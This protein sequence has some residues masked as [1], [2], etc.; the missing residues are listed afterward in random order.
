MAARTPGN[1]ADRPAH[2]V[3]SYLLWIVVACALCGCSRPQ[4]QPR[5]QLQPCELEGVPLEAMCGKLTVFEDREA[6]AGRTIALNIAVV[7]ALNPDPLSDPLF[8]L[9]GGPGQSATKSG[10]MVAALLRGVRNHREIVLVDQRGTG[11]SNPL[12]CDSPGGRSLQKM[13]D[14]T[15]DLDGVRDCAAGLDADPRHYT[16]PVAMDDLD[17]VRA[18]LGYE[19]INLWGGSYGTRAALVYMRRH[20]EHTRRVVLDGPA[21]TDVKLTVHAGRDAQRAL[22]LLF[23]RCQRETACSAEFGDLRRV[24]GDLLA[25]LEAAPHHTRL[26]HPRTGELQAVTITRDALAAAV[27]AILY[28]PHLAALLPMSIQRATQGDWGPLMA[29]LVT[30]SGGMED[31]LADGMFLSVVCAEDIPRI[32]AAERE[33]LRH[34][35]VGDIPVRLLTETCAVWPAA[36]LPE[37]YF[38]PITAAHPT[39]VLSG[40][41][42][43]IVPPSWGDLIAS[44][45]PNARHVVVAGAA[46]GVTPRACISSAISKFLDLADPS[47]LEL[48]C[49]H[50]DRSGLFV[51]FA[52]SFP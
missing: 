40:M 8:V 37:A 13:L 28:V 12:R 19:T 27:R 18:A 33:A 1:A 25:G 24:F 7:Q 20:P 52:G 9:V 10:A 45:L 5:L 51:N 21:P 32:T 48:D 22:D 17:D 42:D 36:T 44:R 16:T 43:P 46:H 11:Q 26:P 23:D 47:K 15:L 38:E 14:V 30:I 39:L 4:E 50:D 2:A 41:L 3:K 31:D 29:G 35:F 34:N 49:E 6:R